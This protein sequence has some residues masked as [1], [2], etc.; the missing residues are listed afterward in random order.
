MRPRRETRVHLGNGALR[1]R[2]DFLERDAGPRGDV[3]GGKREPALFDREKDRVDD[4]L[5][6]HVLAPPAGAVADPCRAAGE[7]V[8]EHETDETVGDPARPVDA[9]ETKRGAVDAVSG[10]GAH[11]GLRGD[12]ARAV[13][14]GRE[15]RGLLEDVA[16]VGLVAIGGDRGQKNEAFDPVPPRR[17]AD[18]DGSAEIDV[19]DERRVGRCDHRAGNSARV[20]DRARPVPLQQRV[21]RIAVAEFGRATGAAAASVVRRSVPMAETP[22]RARRRSS[23]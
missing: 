1:R 4:V 3:V 7:R 11:H 12:L 9:A 8:L 20:H 13:R 6:E 17:L 16:L 21:D 5:D 18:V 10:K 2:R 14:L 22:A 19:E 15:K 23:A